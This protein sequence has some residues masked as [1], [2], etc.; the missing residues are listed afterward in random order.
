[1]ATIIWTDSQGW[2]TDG[3]EE[4]A[5]GGVTII[6]NDGR[7]GDVDIYDY[8]E[9][10]EWTREMEDKYRDMPEKQLRQECILRAINNA[11]EGV[12]MPER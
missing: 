9:D 6:F 10:G 2:P 4:G 11:T 7:C 8:G 3:F 12:R 5:T 1:M